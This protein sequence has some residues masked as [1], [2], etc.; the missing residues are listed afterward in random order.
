MLNPEYFELADGIPSRSAIVKLADEVSEKLEPGL[1]EQARRYANEARAELEG[2][3]NADTMMMNL[4]AG[5]PPDQ[6][7]SAVEI[8]NAIWK[9]YFERLD[10]ET[11]AVGRTNIHSSMNNLCLK[12]LEIYE[13]RYRQRNGWS[14]K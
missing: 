13:Y 5:I 12:S 9:V 6:P 10:Q 3:D 4:R 2:G 11:S 1:L 8:L 7:R 14:T